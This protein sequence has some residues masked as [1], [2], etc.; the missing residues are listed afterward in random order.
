MDK[1]SLEEN[2]KKLDMGS[3]ILYSIILSEIKKYD[4]GSSIEKN[5]INNLLISLTKKN[6]IKRI[7]NGINIGDD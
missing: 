3:L 6:T 2:I 4:E 1:T 7:K 5:E